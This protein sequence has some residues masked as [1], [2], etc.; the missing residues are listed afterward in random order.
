MNVQIRVTIVF[1]LT[2]MVS[3]TN[4]LYAQTQ[5]PEIVGHRGASA[6]APENTLIAAQIAWEA[7]ADGVEVDI[8]MTVDK[9]IVVIHDKTTKRTCGENYIVAETSYDKLRT[10]DA[11]SWKD[12]KFKGEPIPLLTDILNALP[13]G[14]TLY[15]EV[16]S[17]ISIVTELTKLLVDFPKLNQIRIIAFDFDTIAAAK[18]ALPSV[19]CYFLKTIVT[20]GQYKGLIE[21]LKA[22]NLDG[23]DLNYRT[24]SKKLVT[25]LNKAG[26]DCLVWTV[27]QEKS[28]LK[29]YDIG[30]VGITTDHPGAIKALFR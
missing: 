26:M 4:Y 14:K 15:I 10:L 6:L 13:D 25:E 24:V 19:P 7:G 5:G 12:Q 17:E 29:L 20:K 1:F 30:V 21:R 9:R 23:A 3:N 11:G 22:H 2:L 18:A 27:N 28:A 8:H 16:K